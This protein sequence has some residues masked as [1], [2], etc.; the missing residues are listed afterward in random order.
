[1]NNRFTCI[2]TFLFIAQLG[3]VQF[4]NNAVTA[5]DTKSA[6]Q[7]TALA[8]ELRIAVVQMRSS[9]NLDENITKT[10]QHL[11]QCAKDGVRVVVF[12]ECSVTGYFDKPFMQSIPAKKLAYAEQ[13]LVRACKR[14]NIY[15]IA[16]MPVRD[17]DKLYNSAVVFHPSGTIL[18]RYHKV[19]L[20]EDWPD[21]GDHLSVF[22]IDGV[23]CSIIVCHDERYPELVRLPVLAG[24]RIVFYI[25]HESGADKESKIGP[26]RAQIQARAVENSVFIVHANAPANKDLTG[27]HGQSRFIAPDGN[28][29]EEASIYREEVISQTLIPR[30]A[31][32]GLAKRSVQRG[33]LGDWWK[34]GVETVRIIDDP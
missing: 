16:G 20:A 23:P 2:V 6:R 28:I 5:D 33:P 24:A 22:K 3:T 25:S 7:Q 21:G 1:M 26:Y 31:S 12:P 19:Q 14:L 13:K 11:E 17:G 8:D 29:I 18:E 10:I 32:G 15:A 34:A 30:R 27:S 4:T 9:R